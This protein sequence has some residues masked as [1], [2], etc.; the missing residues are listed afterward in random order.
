MPLSQ[1]SGFQETNFQVALDSASE[2]KR[3]EPLMRQE[4]FSDGTK[5]RLRELVVTS[6]FPLGTFAIYLFSSSIGYQAFSI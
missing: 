6:C 3:T 4:A 5:R 2:S 1:Y